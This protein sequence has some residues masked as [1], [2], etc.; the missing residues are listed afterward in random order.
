MAAGFIY[1]VFV[2]NL[3]KVGRC[4]NFP[5][6]LNDYPKGTDML[7]V[8]HV[9]NM[10]KA[11]KMLITLCNRNSHLTL[12]YGREYF[13]GD[14]R[15]LYLCFHQV[16]MEFL[17]PLYV[18]SRA[19]QPLLQILANADNNT[20]ES[21]TDKLRHILVGKHLD[22]TLYRVIKDDKGHR[23]VFS[24]AKGPD[25]VDIPGCRSFPDL[26][27]YLERMLSTQT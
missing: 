8:A 19:Q 13:T 1:I 10:T 5:R 20:A 11:E 21:R 24:V 27:R 14:Y 2:N 15:E 12:T 22:P 6:R 25:W 7:H 18:G 4:A 17:P 16:V 3:Y 23:L 9:D 26:Q